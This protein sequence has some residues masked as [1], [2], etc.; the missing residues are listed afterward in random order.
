MCYSIYES[1][2]NL[3]LYSSEICLVFPIDETGFA[4]VVPIKAMHDLPLRLLDELGWFRDC[5]MS[6]ILVIGPGGEFFYRELL[7]HKH[8][9]KGWNW[10]D[11][12]CRRVLFSYRVSGCACCGCAA[13]TQTVVLCCWGMPISFLIST[14]IIV[15]K[16]GRSFTLY[17]TFAAI[18]PRYFASSS[19]VACRHP[20]NSSK[21]KNTDFERCRYY[22]FS[23]TPKAVDSWSLHFRQI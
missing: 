16:P 20:A 12:M 23:Y 22:W 21:Q 19:S 7:P 15:A 10:G 8:S 9:G 4:T 13:L 11:K 5:L 6:G 2:C 17:Y 14:C 3:H 18:S 1:T